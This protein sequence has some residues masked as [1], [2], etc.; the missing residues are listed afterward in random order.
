MICGEYVIEHIVEMCNEKI[1]E[2]ENNGE[3]I[4]ALEDLLLLIDATK[5]NIEIKDKLKIRAQSI[6]H[7]IVR[8]HCYHCEEFRKS[9]IDEYESL[10][11]CGKIKNLLEESDKFYHDACG[12]WGDWGGYL[13]SGFYK[14]RVDKVDYN[15]GKMFEY[16]HR[17][18]LEEQF[19]EE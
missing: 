11:I 9:I 13:Y 8:E 2:K 12:I 3:Y 17:K 16:E 18:F 15:V 5:F 10:C 6:M 19:F 4:R 14:R 7:N 1:N